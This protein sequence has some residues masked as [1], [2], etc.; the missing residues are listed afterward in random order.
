MCV[1]IVRPII[2]HLENY[3]IKIHWKRGTTI[4][5]AHHKK[6]CVPNHVPRTNT[7][8]SCILPNGIPKTGERERER[9]REYL[10]RAL[11]QPGRDA[12]LLEGDNGCS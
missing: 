2:G 8:I 10:E 6:K 11:D 5:S 12:Q 9:E 3:D 1:S 7:G 4:H